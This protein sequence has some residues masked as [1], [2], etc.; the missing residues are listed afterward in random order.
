MEP[1]STGDE[2]VPDSARR[3]GVYE[4]VAARNAIQ[5]QRWIHAFYGAVAYGLDQV[6]LVSFGLL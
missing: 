5:C 3:G 2:L 4:E 6:Q 1:V